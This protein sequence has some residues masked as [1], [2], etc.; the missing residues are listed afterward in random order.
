MAAAGLFEPHALPAMLADA[1]P[2]CGRLR[3][4]WLGRTVGGHQPRGWEA[5]GWRLRGPGDERP[6][7]PPLPCRYHWG[8][9]YSKAE[10][11][12]SPDQTQ[13]FAERLLSL[14][15]SCAGLQPPHGPRVVALCAD[16]ILDNYGGA[17]PEALRLRKEEAC[18]TY[19]LDMD[20]PS[21]SF[22]R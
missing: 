19:G 18:P 8:Q 14:A 21:D 17:T 3:G 10:S 13:H 7:H 22:C 20:P 9:N 15:A 1:L 16:A 11:T 4:R 6:G 5:A 12:K 2:R